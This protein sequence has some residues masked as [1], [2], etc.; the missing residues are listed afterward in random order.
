[1]TQPLDNHVRTHFENEKV[2]GSQSI[3]CLFCDKKYDN[4]GAISKLVR[5]TRLHTGHKPYICPFQNCDYSAA[6]KSGLHGHLVSKVHR[7]KVSLQLFN[8]ILSLDSLRHR[9]YLEMPTTKKGRSKRRHHSYETE[10]DNIKEEEPKNKRRRLMEHDD[11][12][13][14]QITVNHRG[15]KYARQTNETIIK[16]E[17]E[18]EEDVL[19]REIKIAQKERDQWREN[20]HH[21]ADI[22]C[23][24]KL[25]VQPVSKPEF[26]DCVLEADLVALTSLSYFIGLFLEKVS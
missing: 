21:L 7:G 15:Q 8:A 23:A 2:K 22:I 6:L 13:N 5:H 10:Q 24:N 19:H 1:M 20:Y 14:Q 16:D 11:E 3:Q 4:V 17:D 18:D 25:G 9:P 12:G 26:Q